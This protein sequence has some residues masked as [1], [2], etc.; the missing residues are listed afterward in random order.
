MSKT[1][2]SS[3][4]N[5][6]G[7]FRQNIPYRSI[8]SKM[9]RLGLKCPIKIGILKK[10]SKIWGLRANFSTKIFFNKSKA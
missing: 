8:G 3:Q 1:P 2:F 6:N 7:V 9:R 4:I 5:Q 10:I